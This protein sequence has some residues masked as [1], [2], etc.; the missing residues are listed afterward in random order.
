M[1][2]SFGVIVCCQRLLRLADHSSRGVIPSVVY[3]IECDR[4]ASKNTR[5]LHTKDCHANKKEKELSAIFLSGFTFGEAVEFQFILQ[6][7]LIL[8]LYI[9]KCLQN[10]PS[11][12]TFPTNF[13]VVVRATEIHACWLATSV[14]S[15]KTKMCFLLYTCCSCSNMGLE[16]LMQ[17]ARHLAKKCGHY[18]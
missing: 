7:R 5:L 9:L 11:T 4:E 14:I 13:W 15:A 12:F 18:S 2:L 3:F 8:Y 10:F 6:M 1:S 17:S 16:S